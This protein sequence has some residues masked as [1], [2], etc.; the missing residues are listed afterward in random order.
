M[1]KMANTSR[2]GP[3]F[4]AFFR[5]FAEMAAAAVGSPW[6]F[7]AA[8]LMTIGWALSGKYFGYSDTWQLVINTGTS[9][10]T[11]VIVFLIQHSQ[12]RD[13]RVTQMKLD[14]LIRAVESARTEMIQMEELS[15]EDLEKVQNEHRKERE[16]AV[17]KIKKI[18]NR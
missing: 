12:N 8:V 9:V 11:F 10:L 15:D 7:L 14:E 1:A 4:T 2:D 5:K 18:A 6:A 3:S 16:R 17:R 13:T